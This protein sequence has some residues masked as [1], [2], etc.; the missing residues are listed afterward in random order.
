M[1]LFQ[2]WPFFQPFFLANIGQENVFCDILEQKTP[3]RAIKTKSSKSRKID[4]L[5]K[6]LTQGFGS[7]MAIFPTFLFRQFRPGQCLLRHSRSKK[8]LSKL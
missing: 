2:K 8:R 4:I 3:F 5:R 1:V 7:K 6:G